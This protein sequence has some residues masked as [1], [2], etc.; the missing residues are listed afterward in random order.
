MIA[1]VEV[2][3]RAG[4][5][6]GAA[7][8]R[9][10]VTGQAAE[11]RVGA[12]ELAAAMGAAGGVRVGPTES[13]AGVKAAAMGAAAW[14]TEQTREVAVTRLR[15][16]LTPSHLMSAT[17]RGSWPRSRYAAIRAPTWSSFLRSNV[18]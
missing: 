10:E 3:T 13:A 4:A 11:V 5:M 14:W 2:T 6:E 12:M 7:W 9:E 17:P 15:S 1:A 18:A 8:V 16:E